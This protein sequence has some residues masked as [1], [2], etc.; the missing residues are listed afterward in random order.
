VTTPG[1]EYWSGR[2]FGWRYLAHRVDGLGGQGAWLS[3]ELPV[4]GVSLS[5]VLAGPPQ[6]TATIAPRA[7]QLVAADGL[8]LLLPWKTAI[9]AE[10]DG[11][12]RY[13]GLL[14]ASGYNGPEWSLDVSGFCGYPK[15]MGY[16]GVTEFVDTDP[17]AILRHIWAHIQG[18]QESNLGLVVSGTTSPV[19]LGKPAATDSDTGTTE[20]G[21]Y[22]LARYATQDL[23]NVIDELA[24]NTP[25]EYHERHQWDSTKTY[26]QH[27]LDVGYPR[28]GRRQR[29][30]RF[31]LG[32][33]IEVIPAIDDDGEEY[34]SHVRCLGAGEGSTMVIGEAR[35]VGSGL[36]RMRT[37]ERK[38]LTTKAQADAAARDELMRAVNLTTT[39]A[40]TVRNTEQAP[41]GAWSVGDEIRVQVDTD[42]YGG[43]RGIDLW[44]RVLS[45]TVDPESPDM[46]AMTLLRSDLAAAA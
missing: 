35:Q 1:L 8:P 40:V 12:I 29:D 10:Q 14:V 28:L 17:L 33:N 44:F 23:G 21:P 37:I 20:E 2:S 32:E 6:M 36:R 38:D 24:R 31:V 11:H 4:Q 45:Q 19:R 16:E 9:Y 43:W 25:F 13:G 26:V 22:I 42:G 27:Y 7:A 34:A 3:N 41:L 30:L 5:D 18:G 46:I 15:G 39:P